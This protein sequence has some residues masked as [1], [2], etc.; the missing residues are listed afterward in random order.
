MQYTDNNVFKMPWGKHQGKT[1][2]EMVKKYPGYAKYI[3]KP[4][5]EILRIIQELENPTP[6]QEQTLATGTPEQEDGSWPGDSETPF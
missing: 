5:E 3:T 4:K 6:A 1:I 2:T